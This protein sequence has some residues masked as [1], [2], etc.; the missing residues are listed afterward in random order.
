[1]EGTVMS[2]KIERLD[3]GSLASYDDSTGMAANYQ[4]CCEENFIGILK[5]GWPRWVFYFLTLE[6]I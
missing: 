2:D 6:F 5:E 3:P 4:F 1:M